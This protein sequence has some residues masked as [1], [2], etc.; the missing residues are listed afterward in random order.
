MRNPAA[1]PVQVEHD[2]VAIDESAGK[3]GTGHVVGIQKGML[4]VVVDKTGTRDLPGIVEGGECNAAMG[5][6]QAR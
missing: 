3:I 1:S 4:D 2:A 6:G 5:V